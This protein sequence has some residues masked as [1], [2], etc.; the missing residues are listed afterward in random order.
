MDHEKERLWFRFVGSGIILL[1][2]AAVC[3]DEIRSSCSLSQ[4][5]LLPV[6]HLSCQ[7]TRTTNPWRAKNI[8]QLWNQLPPRVREL[9]SPVCKMKISQVPTI[10]QNKKAHWLQ[11]TLI[12]HP[13]LSSFTSFTPSTAI[14]SQ[15]SHPWPPGREHN[16]PLPV[17]SFSTVSKWNFFFRLRTE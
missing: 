14:R 2:L 11:T 8:T 17:S 9:W 15:Y 13:L 6:N 4:E 1:T 5:Y 12:N 7:Q 3:S 16:R 10:V